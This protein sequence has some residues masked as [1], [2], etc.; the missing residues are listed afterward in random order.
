MTKFLVTKSVDGSF[1]IGINYHEPDLEE[2]EEITGVEAAT[3][4]DDPGND[5]ELGTPE[6]TPN[7]DGIYVQI[8]A[9]REGG[10]Y[11]VLFK[12]TT[13]GGKTFNNPRFDAIRVHVIPKPAP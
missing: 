7:K 6:I 12:W 3:F 9:G 13:S 5:L 8:S 10:K 4:P 2:N 11:L 1:N